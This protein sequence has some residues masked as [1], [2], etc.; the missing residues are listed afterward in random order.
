M[1]GLFWLA[2]SERE[3]QRARELAR[4]LRQTES[5]D[6]L[7]VGSVRDALADLLLPGTSTL[8][9]RARYHLFVPWA[10]QQAVARGGKRSLSDRL[11]DAEAELI[12][13]VK[14]TGAADP[15]AD[16][17][18]LIGVDA[19]R[20]LKRMPSTLYW[21]GLHVWGI[22]RVGGPQ[23][24]I[25]RLLARRRPQD[26]RDDDGSPL[27]PSVGEVWHPNLPP[28]PPNHGEAADFSLTFDE[29]EFLVERLTFE[30]ATRS[31]ALAQLVKVPADHGAV[32]QLWEHPAKRELDQ[33]T[34]FVIEQGR[35]FSLLMHGASW[36]YNVELARMRESTELTD[37]HRASFERWASAAAGAGAHLAWPLDELW[38]V[39]GDRVPPPTRTFVRRWQDLLVSRG[40]DGLVD[41]PDA[42]ALIISRER[43]MKGANARTV[44][45]KA[46]AQWGGRSGTTP[47]DFRWSTARRLIADIRAGLETGD[48]AH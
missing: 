38:A 26:E 5:R 32:D 34:Q 19:G 20:D 37:R 45:A 4:A 1:S 22:R 12:S 47:L 31:S 39:T 3:R 21:Q 23:S 2:T 29:A 11:R 10:Y 41:D 24:V 46:L 35:R 16:A 30:D 7:G 25:E 36:T 15:T 44:N 43:R 8:H 18:G 33:P 9:T 40:P 48:A 14:R 6:E 28:S 42:R 17:D 13:T 27:D